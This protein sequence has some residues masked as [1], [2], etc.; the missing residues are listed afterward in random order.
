MALP[1]RI[2][3]KLTAFSESAVAKINPAV[4]SCVNRG[5]Y[6]KSGWGCAVVPP[7]AGAVVPRLPGGRLVWAQP[8]RQR[9]DWRGRWHIK[10]GTALWFFIYFCVNRLRGL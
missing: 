1:F 10:M 3:P 7:T 2:S 5:F 4:L 8:P 9:Q 6:E